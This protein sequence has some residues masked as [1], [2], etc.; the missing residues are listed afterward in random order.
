MSREQG[1][2]M[3]RTQ[4]KPGPTW[5]TVFD[6]QGATLTVVAEML[7]P[8]QTSPR[9][10]LDQ[11]FTALEGS[12][13]RGAFGR[14]SAIRAVV[15]A[16][17]AYKLQTSHSASGAEAPLPARYQFP[18]VPHIGMLPWPERAVYLLRTVLGY[19]RRDTALLLSMSDANIDQI[20]KF[21]EKRIRRLSS[22]SSPLPD[23]SDPSQTLDR[24]A[25]RR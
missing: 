23:A 9:Q 10:I 15:K 17:V 18:Q 13:L 2:A 14:I 6:E 5:R 12:P 24:I 1:T 22:A 7:V 8:C 20:H 3:K 25:S 4:A 21:A 11:A 19:S 16:A